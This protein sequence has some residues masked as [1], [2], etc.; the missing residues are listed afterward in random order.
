MRDFS[1]FV[2]MSFLDKYPKLK[3]RQFLTNLVTK[4]VYATMALE[5]QKV[6]EAKVRQIVTSLLNQQTSEPGKLAS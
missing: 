3:E 6:E 5:D 2:Q 1:I 4:S